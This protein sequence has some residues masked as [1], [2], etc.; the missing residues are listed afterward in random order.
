MLEEQIFRP[1]GMENCGLG[2]N[3]EESDISIDNP[4]PYTLVKFPKH[5]PLPLDYLSRKYRDN[6]PALNSAGRVHCPVAS[7]AKFLQAHADGARSLMTPLGLSAED[8]QVLHTSYQEEE[9][10]PYTPGAWRHF[11]V[12]G[13]EEKYM[14]THTGS[15]TYNLALAKLIIGLENGELYVA[16]TNVA[17]T[18]AEEGVRATVREMMEGRLLS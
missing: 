4:W 9:D 15:N 5:Q 16:T 3:D 13:S 2:P 7:Y 11:N 17:G 1:L 8:F 14:L 6:P 18:A 12:S 10:A